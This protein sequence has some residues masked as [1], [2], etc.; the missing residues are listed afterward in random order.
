[1]SYTHGTVFKLIESADGKNYVD[2][3][4]RRDGLFEFRAYDFKHGEYEGDYWEA[5]YISGL[6]AGADVAESEAR[7]T[8]PWLK[9][10]SP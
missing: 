7:K 3:V 2:I 5:S 8:V 1:M 9:A 10:D 6:Y 4:S